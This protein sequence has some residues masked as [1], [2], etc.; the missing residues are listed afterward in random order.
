MGSFN[1]SE[2]LAW[3]KMEWGTQST[4]SSPLA[5]SAKDL[6]VFDVIIYP[7]KGHSFHRHPHQEE[8]IYVLEGEVEQWIDGDKQLSKTG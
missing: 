1:K 3:D 5:V 8:V 6:M 2:S 7:G 4:V